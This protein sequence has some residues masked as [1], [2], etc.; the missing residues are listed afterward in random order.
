MQPIFLSF[1]F[2]ISLVPKQKRLGKIIYKVQES[3]SFCSLKIIR[4]HEV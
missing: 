3:L 1:G 2:I 4:K